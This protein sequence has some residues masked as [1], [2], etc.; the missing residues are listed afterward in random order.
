LDREELGLATRTY[1]IDGQRFE[2]EI[3]SETES[4]GTARVN[5]KT[6]GFER[7]V[8]ERQVTQPAAPPAA[9]A[10]AH[11]PQR[12][13]AGEVRAPMAGRILKLE[14]E[15][16]AA[17]EAGEPLLVLDAMKMENT[18]FAP[19][20]GLVREI[21]VGVG[22]TVLQGALLVRMSQDHAKG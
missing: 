7:A 3:L 16:G 12:A 8:P 20:T 22:D 13:S 11:A 17:I 1:V 2:V 5:G 4:G 15:D 18:I 21:A 10:H 6:Y 19:V 14:V 9:A